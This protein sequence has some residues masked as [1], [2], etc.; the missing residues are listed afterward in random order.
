MKAENETFETILENR[1]QSIY[2]KLHKAK[3]EIGKVK[4]G[5]NNQFFK[6]KYAD[7]NSLIEAVEPT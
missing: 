6:S 7:L 3:L 5:S 4:K 1:K 2:F